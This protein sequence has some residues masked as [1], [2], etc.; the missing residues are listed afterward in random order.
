MKAKLKCLKGY[1]KQY[2]QSK[3]R[4]KQISINWVNTNK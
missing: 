3:P 2:N 1:L 4:N